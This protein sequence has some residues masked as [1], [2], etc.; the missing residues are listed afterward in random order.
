[1]CLAVK[2]ID[3]C[4]LLCPRD[5]SCL[6]FTQKFSLGIKGTRL[7]KLTDILYILQQ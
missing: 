2:N 3:D 7:Q 6:S 1:M 5:G 4:N